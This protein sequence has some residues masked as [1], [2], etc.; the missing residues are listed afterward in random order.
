MEDYYISP[1]LSLARES[2]KGVFNRSL[3]CSSKMCCK[4]RHSNAKGTE[5]WHEISFKVEI[6]ENDQSMLTDCTE[7]LNAQ[8]TWER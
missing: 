4:S 3:E 1:S 5:K 6:W 2:V 8:P 7:F